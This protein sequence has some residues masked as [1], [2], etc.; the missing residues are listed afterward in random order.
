[1]STPEKNVEIVNKYKRIA[2]DELNRNLTEF[3]KAQG[4]DLDRIMD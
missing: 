3:I 1:L 2:R 4:L